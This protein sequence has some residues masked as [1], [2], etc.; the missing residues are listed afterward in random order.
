MFILLNDKNPLRGLGSYEN[1]RI[2]TIDT[3][4][5]LGERDM[6]R[7]ADAFIALTKFIPHK[8]RDLVLRWA[9]YID[10]RYIEIHGTNQLVQELQ[11][12]NNPEY[13]E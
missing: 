13:W 9:G 12:M 10:A 5:S 2:R 11:K 6:P 7:R 8:A 4:K 3:D 1:L